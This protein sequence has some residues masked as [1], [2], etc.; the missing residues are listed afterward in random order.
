[1]MLIVA[2][3]ESKLVSGAPVNFVSAACALDGISTDAARANTTT[4]FFIFLLI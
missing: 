2:P 1:M 4:I 3:C